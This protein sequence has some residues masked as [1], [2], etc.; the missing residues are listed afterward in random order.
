[1]VSKGGLDSVE[2]NILPHPGIEEGIFIL[3]GDA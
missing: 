1:M 3:K 2:K